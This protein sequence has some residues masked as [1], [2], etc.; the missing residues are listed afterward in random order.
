MPSND[1]AESLVRAVA[2]Q[3]N[4]GRVL[5]D[6]VGPLLSA[7]GLRLHLLRMDFSEA[8][9]RV[10]EVMELLDDAMERVRALSQTLNPSP[11][12]RTGLKNALATLIE[13]YRQTFA[14][15]LRFTF[16]A[17]ARVQVET[18]AAIYDAA[19]AALAAAVERGDATKNRGFGHRIEAAAGANEG[20]WPVPRVASQPGAGRAPGPPRRAEL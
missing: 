8:A 2:D 5:H 11:V 18:A 7:A 1:L 19:A 15:Q 13:S 17:S 16:T 3:R 20:Q 4:A 12:Y 10:R 9:E 14:G 6:D